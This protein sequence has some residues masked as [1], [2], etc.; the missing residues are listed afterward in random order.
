MSATDARDALELN[1]RRY[2]PALSSTRL[3]AL[4]AHADKYASALAAQDVA[5]ASAMYEAVAAHSRLEAAAAEYYGTKGR[6]A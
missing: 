5:R 6:A 2:F 4:M 1:L 3:A